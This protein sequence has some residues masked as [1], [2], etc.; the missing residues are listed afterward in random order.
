MSIHTKAKK[1][2]IK[3]VIFDGRYSLISFCKSDSCRYCPNIKTYHLN[4]T[5]YDDRNNQI[6][7]INE[8]ATNCSYFS[9]TNFITVEKNS[10]LLLESVD[11]QYFQQQ[12]R[13]FIYSE[14]LSVNLTYVNFKRIQANANKA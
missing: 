8:Y 11:V 6:L 1:L 14:G 9:N 7:E 10:S 13:S 5:Y 3:N 4:Q 12:Y 2:T